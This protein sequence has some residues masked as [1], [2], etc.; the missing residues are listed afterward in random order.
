MKSI[1]FSD[2]HQTIVKTET[3]KNNYKKPVYKQL[4]S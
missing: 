1:H 3:E 4:L 2:L